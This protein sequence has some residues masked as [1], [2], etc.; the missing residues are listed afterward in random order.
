MKESI[1][2]ELSGSPIATEEVTNFPRQENRRH[3]V[4]GNRSARTANHD[5]AARMADVLQARRVST[6]PE[7]I[8]AFFQQLTRERLRGNDEFLAIVEVCGFRF[9]EFLNQMLD[10]PV[11][12]TDRIDRIKRPKAFDPGE[13]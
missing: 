8:Q 2:L 13:R 3:V 4:P 12:A 10:V 6:Q 5:L 9:L 7:K 11:R 1:L